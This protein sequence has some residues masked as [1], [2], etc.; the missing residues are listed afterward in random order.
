[1]QFYLK[2]CLNS[3]NFRRQVNCHYMP[4]ST[5]LYISHISTTLDKV[6]IQANLVAGLAAARCSHPHTRSGWEPCP[7]LCF[8]HCL[9]ITSA[10][11]LWQFSH[12]IR[13]GEP[14]LFSVK[15]IRKGL[16]W[17]LSVRGAAV[18]S[19]ATQ[20]IGAHLPVAVR[21]DNL[22]PQVNLQWHLY[23]PVLKQR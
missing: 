3:M 5:Y 23:C 10:S 22:P 9:L 14:W 21:K 13:K 6:I 16:L 2:Y 18:V 12:G 8:C 19:T 17:F 20:L 4:L 15:R 1:M 7:L 11:S